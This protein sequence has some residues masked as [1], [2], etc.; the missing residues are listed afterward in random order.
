MDPT[1][2]PRLAQGKDFSQER[3]EGVGLE[4]AQ[5]EQELLLRR[6][7]RPFAAAAGE[8]LPGSAGQG[9]IGAIKPLIG[10]RE[11]GQQD[12]KFSTC[13]P[14]KGQELPTITLKLY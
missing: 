1:V 14:S 6:V 3:V 4:V 7:E 8:P 12:L 13:Q 9:L 5:P 2:H 11:G 10:P